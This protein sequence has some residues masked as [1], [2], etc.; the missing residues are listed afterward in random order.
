MKMN[1]LTLGLIVAALMAIAPTSV[2]SKGTEKDTITLTSDNTIV[3]NEVVDG[4]SVGK[5]ITKAKEL[6][7]TLRSKLP[8]SKPIYLVLN[9]PGGS[10]QS[11]LE[12]VEALNGMDR[13]VN[14]ITQFAASM[15]FQIAQNLKTRAITKSGVLMSHRA[16][17]GFEGEFG[18]E[19][20][21][22][23]DSRYALWKSRMDELDA[24]TASRT[25]GKRTLAQ[26]QHE[27]ASEMWRTGQQ[28]VDEGYA[29][30]VVQ[31]R[32]DSSLAGSTSHSLMYMG[33]IPVTYDIDNCP[34]NTAPMNVRVGIATTRGVVDS[35]SFTASNGGY[36][37]DCL[38]KLQ[39]PNNKDALCAL[40]TSLTMSKLTQLKSEFTN[41]YV[42][43][44]SRVGLFSERKAAITDYWGL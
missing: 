3:L 29:D 38:L 20:P 41:A 44:R 21:S 16:K 2:L 24:Q 33:V 1:K 13:P 30:Q 36:G 32:C 23:I 28:S 34:L 8:G 35:D 22:Q 11:G 10:V 15:G 31:V 39:N 6:N 43:M 42:N 17:G 5:V 26:Y 25:G 18:G 7:A 4:E 19:A 40:D 9:T 12:L 14:T 37:A 27:Y